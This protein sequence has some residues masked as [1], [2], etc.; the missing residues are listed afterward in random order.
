MR[1][2]ITALWK[3]S[4]QLWKQRNSELHGT[5]SAISLERRHKEAADAAT[6][7]YQQTLGKIPITDSYVL[8]HANIDELLHWNK[9]QLDAYLH[10]AD[11]II[12]QRDEP[13]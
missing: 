6:H 10:S 12:E 11:I 3:F 8:H 9:E 1:T 4:I 7:M 13:D 5:N 2:V